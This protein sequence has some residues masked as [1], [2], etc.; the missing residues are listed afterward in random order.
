MGRQT[1]VF[2]EPAGVTSFAG[3]KKLVE[4]G[5]INEDETVVIVVSG[6]GLKDVK[7]AQRAVSRPELVKPDINELVNYLRDNKL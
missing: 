3:L 5:K 2:G 1:G 4:L 6:S 7:S